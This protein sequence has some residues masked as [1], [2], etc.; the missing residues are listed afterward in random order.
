M[1]LSVLNNIYVNVQS[2][3][4]IA[5]SRVLYFDP[6][7]IRGEYHDADFVFITHE[8]FDHY[9]VDDIL[10]VIQLNTYIICPRM[11]VDSLMCVLNLPIEQ[12]VGIN[13]GENREIARLMVEG[14]PAYNIRKP[15]HA[16]RNG[17]L[18]YVVTLDGTRYYISGDTDITPESREVRCDLAFLSIG[19]VYAMDAKDAAKLLRYISPKVVIPT[20]YGSGVG[21]P[22]DGDF[23]SGIVPRGIECMLY[24]K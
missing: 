11:M 19:G 17:W 8:H 16:R 9:S 24:L 6:W 15:F 12:F 22:Y 23:F 2:S 18:G 1:D 5:G 20:G 7:Q 3:I 4:R 10:K 14:I 13:P 21:S